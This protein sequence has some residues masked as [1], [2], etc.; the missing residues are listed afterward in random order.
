MPIEYVF[1]SGPH[2]FMNAFL[3]LSICEGLNSSDISCLT[4]HERNQGW[5]Q[6]AK[7][8]VGYRGGEGDNSKACSCLS[9]TL[10]AVCRGD[11]SK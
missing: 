4:D 5:R 3:I 8:P 9:D 11:Q 6:L 2:I 7:L 10:A 1:L